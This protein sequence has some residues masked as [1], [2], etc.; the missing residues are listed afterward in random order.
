MNANQSPI[1]M[2]VVKSLVET[3][4]YKAVREIFIRENIPFKEVIYDLTQP[5]SEAV[6]RRR[7]FDFDLYLCFPGVSDP[8][9]DTMWHYVQSQYKPLNRLISEVDMEK[10]LFEQDVQKRSELYRDFER[11]QIQDPFLIPLLMTGSM[12]LVKPPL[13]PPSDGNFEWGVQ[14]WKFLESK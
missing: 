7:A 5:E 6:K 2:F 14:L 9:P 13:Q 4:E 12:V 8:D 3:P 11:R 10:A 1:E